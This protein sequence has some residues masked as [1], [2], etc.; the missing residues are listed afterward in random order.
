MKCELC[1]KQIETIYLEKILGT[2]IKDAKGKKHAVC[3]EC[4]YKFNNDKEE[5]L[6][7][8]T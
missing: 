4:H 8:L 2:F 6:K 5:M 3:S 1:T 7:N